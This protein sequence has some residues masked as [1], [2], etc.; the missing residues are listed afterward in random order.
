M[1]VGYE[2]LGA[3]GRAH[4][5]F[6]EQLARLAL[7]SFERTHR[8]NLDAYK[9]FWERRI[10]E[11]SFAAGSAPPAMPG[12]ATATAFLEHWARVNETASY[13]CQEFGRLASEYAEDVKNAV[14]AAPDA[15]HASYGVAR[16]D[17]VKAPN[18]VAGALAK[19]A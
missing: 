3:L 18:T 4:L 14:S 17:R 2:P 12:D 6:C 9:A 11:T 7:E 5:G 16:A 8:I 15:A 19:A 10:A 1:V 13:L